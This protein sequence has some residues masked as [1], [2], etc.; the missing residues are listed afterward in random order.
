MTIHGAYQL[1]MAD[2]TGSLETG[3]WADLQIVDRNPYETPVAQLDQ[4]RPLGVYV[5]GR[6]QIALP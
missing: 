6:A 4:L 2:K 3:K 5:G 1:R